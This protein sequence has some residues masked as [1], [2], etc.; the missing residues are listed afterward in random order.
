LSSL[1]LV[2]SLVS[3]VFVS[4]DSIN[5]DDSVFFVL[6]FFS[7]SLAASVCSPLGVA[8]DGDGV[9]SDDFNG[10]LHTVGTGECLLLCG[11]TLEEP[12]RLGEASGD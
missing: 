3:P 5:S 9:G 7:S 4:E 2:L 11:C 8:V 6:F 10:P 1:P 12:G